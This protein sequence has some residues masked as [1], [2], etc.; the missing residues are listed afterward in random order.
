[1]PERDR[2][3][4]RPD[5]FPDSSWLLTAGRRDIELEQPGIR[6]AVSSGD[7]GL[8]PVFMDEDG[9]RIVLYG[10]VFAD[11]VGR[12]DRLRHIADLYRRHGKDIVHQLE[13]A[14]V[15]V[16]IDPG[17][18]MVL[19]FNDPAGQRPM[20]AR[21]NGGTWTFAPR[22]SLV[23]GTGME[24]AP[25]GLASFVASGV[26]LRGATP[27]HG[28]RWLAPAVVW[29]ARGNEASVERYWDYRFPAADEESLSP[30]ALRSLWDTA[31]RRSVHLLSAGGE[32]IGILLTGGHDSGGL[33]G[34]LLD[35]G[36]EPA[37]LHA[38]TWTDMPEDARNDA[39]IAVA[40]SKTAGIRHTSLRYAHND[41]E[42]ELRAVVRDTEALTDAQA[43][44][45]GEYRLMRRLRDEFDARVLWQ[46]DQLF[47]V[48]RAVRNENDAFNSLDVRPLSAL[49]TVQGLLTRNTAE[50][51][52]DA[53][54]SVFDTICD[55]CPYTQPTDRRDYWYYHLRHQGFL[56]GCRHMRRSVIVERNPLLMPGVLRET[57][58]APSCERAAGR[59]WKRLVREK[60]PDLVP[61]VE[62]VAALLP[63]DRL[64]REDAAVNAVL[65]RH[66]VDAPG[67]LER[68]FEIDALRAWV[69]TVLSAAAPAATRP[70][71][72]LLRQTLS[73]IRPLKHAVLVGHRWRKRYGHTPIESPAH[74]RLA[75]RILML[76]FWLEQYAD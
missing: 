14:Y 57:V 65:R 8:D 71:R 10:E 41:I 58:K 47:G 49:P 63:T 1:M 68:F 20:F 72:S 4:S 18:D 46:G 76:K 59:L 37:R 28:V 25:A 42:E 64:V 17:R 23:A 27:W 75:L 55:A 69:E 2:A 16:I 74:G 6:I 24:L 38:F 53:S 44:H 70:C 60:F 35:A 56:N 3:N 19:L 5:E 52:I 43:Y 9:T 30:T 73:R 61:D 50:E 36:V 7:D 66:L 22:P 15:V 62:P 12:K 31:I 67:P 32:R 21:E 13:G 33:L 39:G 45:H 40:R 48:C 26:F 51:W 29:H 54:E 11:S 34:Y